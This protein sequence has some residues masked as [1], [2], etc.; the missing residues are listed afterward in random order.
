[1]HAMPCIATMGDRSF[2]PVNN[3]LNFMHASSL[4]ASSISGERQSIGPSAGCIHV[5]CPCCRTC[6]ISSNKHGYELASPGPT[7]PDEGTRMRSA[8]SGERRRQRQKAKASR[9]CHFRSR[10]MLGRSCLCLRSCLIPI[11]PSTS[12]NSEG[13]W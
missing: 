9:R 3:S 13:C 11:V 7:L 10:S 6:E 12:L 5:A 1:M 4:L 8:S 2:Y